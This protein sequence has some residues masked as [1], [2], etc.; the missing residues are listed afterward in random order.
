[1]RD[2]SATDGIVRLRRGEV[3]QVGR[4]QVSQ[5]GVA[6]GRVETPS[7]R[8]AS[9]PVF[10]LSKRDPA[11]RFSSTRRMSEQMLEK[12]GVML[13]PDQWLRRSVERPRNWYSTCLTP[14]KA[15][16]NSTSR[17]RIGLYLPLTDD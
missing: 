3:W 15:Q 14:R 8:N 17:P 5:N 2:T 4:R 7:S 13:L 12:D 11:P 1:M 6:P 16:C 10:V 9:I